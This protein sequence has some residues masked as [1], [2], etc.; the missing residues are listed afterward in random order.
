VSEDLSHGEVFERFPELRIVMCHCGGALDRFIPT[1]PHLSQKDL[2]R[3]LFFDTCAYDL[4]VL[5]AAI[6]QRTL[7]RMCF[8]TEV[9]GSGTAVRPETGRPGDDL[10]PVIGGFRFLSEDDKSAIVNTNSGHV[11]PALAKVV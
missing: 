11:C 1:D 4:N 9:P 7:P 8:G 3:N 10:V 6:K 5:E 2:S